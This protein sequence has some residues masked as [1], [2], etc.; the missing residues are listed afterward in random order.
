M[1]SASSTGG[2]E[3]WFQTFKTPVFT[4]DGQVLGTCGFALDVTE[5]RAAEEERTRLEERLQRAEKMEALGTL[6][7]GV[8]HDLNNIL[9]VVVGYAELLLDEMS[10]IDTG[11]TEAVEILKGGQRA[12]AVVQDLLTLARRGIQRR[13][14]LNLNLV[15]RECQGSAEFARVISFHTRIAIKVDFDVDLLNISGSP[16]HLE[17]SFMNLVSNA[18]DAMPDGGSLMITTRNQYLDKPVS[19]YD[20]VK[21]GDYVV[22]TVS[23][24][25]EGIAAGDLK[26]I[27]EPFYSRKVM[28][29]SGTGL[30]LAVVWGTVKDHHGYINVESEVGKGTTFMLYFPVTREELTPEQVAVS[31]A[32][33][34]GGGETVLIV[35]DVREQRELAKRMLTRLNYKALTAA[36]GEEALEYLRRHAVDL[37]IL[38]MIMEPGMDGLDTYVGVLEMHPR[39]RAIVVSGFS[40]TERVGR[41]QELGAGAYIRKPYVLETLGKAVRRELD[42]PHARSISNED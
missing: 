4:P 15:L 25:G 23:D 11:K 36:S 41:A 3:K 33:Y 14:V 24:T 5:R 2:V 7:G 35:D 19:G 31:A 22:L 40:E 21:E 34:M 32:E 39:Q 37:L 6:A 13:K 18:V 1:R 9:G 26:R 10:R 8:A 29:R 30:G 42:R 28:G 27:F 17:K 12:A 16:I 20:E 38:D